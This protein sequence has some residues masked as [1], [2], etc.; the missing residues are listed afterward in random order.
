MMDD[1]GFCPRVQEILKDGKRV[2]EREDMQARIALIPII[3]AL[4]IVLLIVVPLIGTG[5]YISGEGR[6][7]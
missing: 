4:M 6:D 2:I 3:F 1:D 7:R 5:V